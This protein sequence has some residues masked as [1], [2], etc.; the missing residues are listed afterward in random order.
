MTFVESL[1]SLVELRADWL[2]RGSYGAV[3]L[4]A[5]YTA[6]YET[7][8]RTQPNVRTTVDF[9]ARNVAQLGLHVFRRVSDTDRERLTDHPLA[10]L[11]GR[12]NPRTTRYRL[13]ESLMI[14]FGVHWNAYWLKVKTDDRDALVR[15]PPTCV[16]VEG[17]LLPSRYW[18]T[19]GGP[20]KEYAPDQVIHFRGHGRLLQGLSPLETLRR[21]LAE[22]YE[23]GAYR[24]GLWK[25][26]ARMSG[27][28]ERP[29][30]APEWSPEARERFTSEFSVR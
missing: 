8:Y 22:E 26:A 19:L 11:I 18:I 15:I 5:N 14:D 21:V 9:L 12:P 4:A 27:I 28:V 2:P 24:A 17:G 6:D 23:A 29:A 25:N 3:Q 16:E 10:R 13:I 20:R 1:G 7:I 30:A